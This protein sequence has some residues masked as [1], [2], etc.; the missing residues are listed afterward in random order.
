[1]QILEIDLPLYQCVHRGVTFYVKLQYTPDGRAKFEIAD[2]GDTMIASWEELSYATAQD[3]ESLY[4]ALDE[5][6]YNATPE[7]YANE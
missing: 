4:E 5:A 2:T 6:I 3:F 7:I 1:M